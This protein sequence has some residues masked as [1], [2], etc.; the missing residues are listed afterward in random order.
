VSAED[1]VLVGHPAE[2]LQHFT[3]TAAR[4]QVEWPPQ[5]DVFR[6]YS[7]DQVIE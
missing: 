3:F 2:G 6:Y 7:V 1:P 5:A 4:R